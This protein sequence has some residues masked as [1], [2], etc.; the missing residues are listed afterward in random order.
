[1]DLDKK[2]SAVS[3]EPITH[4]ICESCSRHFTATDLEPLRGFLDALQPPILLVD[5]SCVVL[6]A[7]TTACRTLGLDPRMVE[8]CPPG[9]VLRCA[10]AALPDGC[11][12]TEQCPA[13]E[14]RGSV[15]RTFETGLAM[16]HVSACLEVQGAAGREQALLR[17]S[18]ER[19]NGSVLLRLDEMRKVETARW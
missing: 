6:T 19:V 1:V 13:C 2:G 18:T 9:N 11:G 5:S 7:N 12:K 16:D 10:N 14:I 3:G 15:A 8:G 4:G 17:V